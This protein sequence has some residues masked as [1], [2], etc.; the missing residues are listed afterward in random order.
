[1]EAEG[2]AASVVLVA[3]TRPAGPEILCVSRLMGGDKQDSGGDPPRKQEAL[4]T[5]SRSHLPAL[6]DTT[7]P[8][9]RFKEKTRRPV[10][11]GL[12]QLLGLIA[13]G[14]NQVNRPSDAIAASGW[15]TDPRPTR[16]PCP[17]A[18]VPLRLR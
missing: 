13:N 4:V 6:V 15:W 18:D 10:L 11:A 17:W 5:N 16:A 9:E 12:D 2:T 14:E 1:M 8:Q 7:I 3:R